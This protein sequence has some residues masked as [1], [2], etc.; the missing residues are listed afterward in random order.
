MGEF[1]D[2]LSVLSVRAESPDGQIVGSVESPPQAN[3]SF[4][5]RAYRQ[6]SDGDLGHQLGQLAAVLFVRYRREYD[7]ILSAYRDLPA[8]AGDVR[9]ESLQEAT[10][11]ERQAALVVRGR[12]AR[13][14]LEVSTRALLRW[15]VTVTEGTVSSLSESEFLAEANSL[16]AEVLRD[17]RNQTALLT[18]EIYDIGVPKW[19]TD[20]RLG[21]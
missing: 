11:R 6:Y 19:L 10:F 16:V 21:R 2:R 18:N 3:I 15:D 17:W 13:G 7:E 14:R 9:Y 4:R 20:A 1:A 5:D 8:E 12:S